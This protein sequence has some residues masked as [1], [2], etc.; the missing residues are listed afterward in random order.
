MALTQH[1]TKTPGG[2]FPLSNKGWGCIDTEHTSTGGRTIHNQIPCFSYAPF[3]KSMVVTIFFSYS[4]EIDQHIDSVHRFKCA[5]SHFSGDGRCTNSC[6]NISTRGCRLNYWCQV[7]RRIH[8]IT[9]FILHALCVN[10]IYIWWS[11]HT[12]NFYF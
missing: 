9:D 1:F 7:K 3:M 10:I 4:I 2:N 8:T 5:E 11:V 12:V 6:P